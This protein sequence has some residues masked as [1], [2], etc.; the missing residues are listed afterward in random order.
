MLTR[1]IVA[2]IS[3]FIQILNNYV[4]YLKLI[5]YFM[6]IIF[7]LKKYGGKNPKNLWILNQNVLG[8]SSVHRK[9]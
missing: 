3:Q 7:Q 1:L 9:H 8:L 4:I 6:P 5:P 2:I